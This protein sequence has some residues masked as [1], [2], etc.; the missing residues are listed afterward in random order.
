M[1]LDLRTRIHKSIIVFDIGGTWFRS[2]LLTPD[3][4]LIFVSKRVAINFKNS[5][6]L[7]IT[8]LQQGL[9]DYI[10]SETR[11]L[12]ATLPDETTNLVS[13]SMGAALNSHTGLIL[14]SGPLWGPCSVPFDLQAALRNHDASMQWVV[15]NDI[16]AALLHYARLYEHHG[17]SKLTLVTVSTGI[18][19]RTYDARSNSV[20]V[21]R[22]QGLQGEIGHLPV[23]FRYK[24]QLLKL[25][26]DC[27][28]SNHM[29]AFCSGRGIESVIQ[30]LAARYPRNS[31]AISL[32]SAVQLAPEQY[33]LRPFADALSQGNTFARDILD[34]VTLPLA[35]TLLS[36]FTID[37]EV[38]CVI[39]TGGVINTL[40]DTYI[41]TLLHHLETAGLYQISRRDPSFFRTRIRVGDPDDNAGL[42]GAAI[43]AELH[44][45]P[46]HALTSDNSHVA[47]RNSTTVP[48]RW[49][50]QAQSTM[51]YSVVESNS[52]FALSNPLI[53]ENIRSYLNGHDNR[54]F[55]IV[56]E[57]VDKVHGLRIR[58]YFRHHNVKYHIVPLRASERYKGI[59]AVMRCIQEMD[60]FG[61]PRRSNPIIA[62]GGGVLLDVVGLAAS[63]YRRGVP[64]IRIP[65]TLLSLVD[66]AVGVKVGVNFAGHKNRI[67]SYYPPRIA[68]LDPTFLQSLDRRQI[69]SGLAEILKVAIV[70][71]KRLFDLLES[72]GATLIRQRFQS[73]PYSNLVVRYTIQDMLDEL[74]PNLWERKL[75]RSLDFG[76]SFSPAIE[77][78]ARPRILHGE[79]VALDMALS[80]VLAQQRGLLSHGDL[81]RILDLMAILSLPIVNAICDPAL[82]YQALQDT[83]MH[84]GG[85]QR[86]P[87]PISIGSVEFYNNV[88]STEIEVAINALRQR[89]RLPC[90]G[91]LWA[92]ST[93]RKSYC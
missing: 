69:R 12:R 8:S 87:L 50:V 5:P 70:R 37:P 28:G 60:D 19:C 83:T 77:L 24:K 42:L 52:L 22:N 27:G 67:G 41:E 55:I 13:I 2:G 63:L 64:Y 88:S 47:N 81:N 59:A 57:R 90:F 18:G 1:S 35:N 85:L 82:L 32:L 48:Y 79:A 78:A 92:I 51:G 93:H 11:R 72:H 86:L 20:P 71:D 89:N 31:Q 75:E 16:T 68:F 10:T 21:D 30:K 91:S 74:V 17:L 46:V 6:N 23:V 34:S 43:A 61:V 65:T 49:S 29:N 66:A 15:V 4:R 39:L 3:N 80:S 54:Q 84:R 73:I 36:L 53:R 38:E 40:G 7:S 33:R 45:S 58:R 44:E 56:D 9:V 62:I 26:C 14:N 25:I 76:H